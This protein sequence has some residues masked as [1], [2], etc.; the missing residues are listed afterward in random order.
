[1]AL[2]FPLSNLANQKNILLFVDVAAE[3]K[4]G[5]DESSLATPAV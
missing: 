4:D 1:M 5:S 2:F 3:K